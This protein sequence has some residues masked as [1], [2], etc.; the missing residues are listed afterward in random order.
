MK[1]H[2]V[3]LALL[4]PLAAHAVDSSKD[5]YIG[6]NLS[7]SRHTVSMGN[8]AFNSQTKADSNDSGYGLRAGFYSHN[9]LSWEV[10]YQDYGKN[11]R[12]YSTNGKVESKLSSFGV[13]AIGHLPLNDKLGLYGR[14]GLARVE[15]KT[16]LSGNIGNTGFKSRKT[17]P[18]IGVG[19]ETQ[20]TPEMRGYVEYAQ[21][22]KVKSTTGGAEDSHSASRL[23]A[24]VTYHY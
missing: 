15:S 11:V 23:S 4:A 16:T 7:L 20:L 5:E 14:V 24:G 10:D 6:G 2:L 9:N 8:P 19:L 21:T 22:G 12:T 17:T 1:K 13:S 3:L 18:V